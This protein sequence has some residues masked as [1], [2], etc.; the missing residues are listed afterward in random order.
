MLDPIIDLSEVIYIAGIVNALVVLI[1]IIGTMI[2]KYRPEPH[3][4][5]IHIKK[6]IDPLWIHSIHLLAKDYLQA[7]KKE[8]REILWELQ[9]KLKE[10]LCYDDNYIINYF[11]AKD[12]EFQEL[13][14]FEIY[15]R[16]TYIFEIEK[17]EKGMIDNNIKDGTIYQLLKRYTELAP[18]LR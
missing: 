9:V 18:I 1:A 2:T 4:K 13:S 15:S 17:Y 8:R 7:D 16:L 12:K 14:C 6:I 11:S 3:E 5:V 10:T